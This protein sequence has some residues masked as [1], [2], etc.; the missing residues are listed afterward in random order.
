MPQIKHPVAL[1]LTVLQRRAKFVD[2]VDTVVVKV[3]IVVEVELIELTLEL[4]VDKRVLS[5]SMADF[6]LVILPSKT[7]GHS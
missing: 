2:N 4:K 6:K 1:C 3:E 7:R 5:D